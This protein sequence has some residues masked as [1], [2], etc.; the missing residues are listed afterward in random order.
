MFSTSSARSL[1][2]GVSRTFGILRKR[3]SRMMNRNAS[4]PIFPLPM[5]SWRS[6]REPRPVL[7]SLRW[8]AETRSLAGRCLER[9][10]R[11]DFRQ[12]GED[13]IERANY[14]RE[15]RGLS[16]AEMRSG[17]H[18]Q[19]RQLELVRAHEFFRKRAN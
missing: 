16:R 5:C 8:S 15:A 18:D 7:E 11:F 17:M 1:P 6:T 10:P 13:L 3:R 14:F 2:F 4:R 9:N 19:K 12:A